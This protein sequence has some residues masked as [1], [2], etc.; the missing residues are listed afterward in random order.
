MHV[1]ACL[2]CCTEHFWLKH[3]INLVVSRQTVLLNLADNWMTPDEHYG[4]IHWDFSLVG[5]LGHHGLPLY[6]DW[7]ESML[8]Q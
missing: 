5:L 7:E 8:P 1:I 3:N 6:W 4:D 2:E